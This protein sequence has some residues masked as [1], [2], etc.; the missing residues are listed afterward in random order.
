MVATGAEPGIEGEGNENN[1]DLMEDNPHGRNGH[2][3]D[4]GMQKC[5]PNECN[6]DNGQARYR[7][8]HGQDPE[9]TRMDRVLMQFYSMQGDFQPSSPS[10]AEPGERRHFTDVCLSLLGYKQ[11]CLNYLNDVQKYV[12]SRM[13]PEMLSMLGGATPNMVSPKRLACLQDNLFFLQRTIFHKE[14]G[15]DIPPGTTMHGVPDWHRVRENNASK[16]CSTLRQLVRDWSDEGQ[17]ERETCYEPILNALERYLPVSEASR[18]G[19][20]K[21]PKVICPGSGLGRLPFD[22][23]CRGYSAVGN[24][25]SYQMLFVTDFIFNCTKEP[26][27]HII[28]PWV[29]SDRNRKNKDDQFRSVRVPNLCPFEAIMKHR[30]P[31]A[32]FAMCSGEFVQIFEGEDFEQFDAL[33]TCYFIDT[34]RNFVEYVRTFAKILPENRYWINIGPL[35]W[36]FAEDMDEMSV[37]LSWEQCS[38]IINEYFDIVELETNRP[39]CYASDLNGMQNTVFNCVFFVARRN[40][41]PISGVSNDP[42]APVQW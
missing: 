9:K 26:Y 38:K 13:T 41:R 8:P 5:N 28:Y 4:N 7:D 18:R 34:A 29:T 32:D 14:Q 35:L 39:S 22:A 21:P 16:A 27:E 42:Y 2:D 3:I 25:F 37:E 30:S 20:E 1:A 36:H 6:I 33:L 17:R 23:L 19:D 15:G 40:K 12:D 10:L 24:E 31:L 11:S